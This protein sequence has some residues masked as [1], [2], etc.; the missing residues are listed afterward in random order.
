MGCNGNPHRVS[1]LFARFL[2]IPTCVFCVFMLL[3]SH[4]VLYL[5]LLPLDK[6][7]A[8]SQTI[9]S[10]AISWMQSII[11]II[12]RELC[13][14]LNGNVI[15]IKLSSL[16]ALL[17]SGESNIQNAINDNRSLNIMR[18]HIS[19]RNWKGGDTLWHSRKIIG[20]SMSSMSYSVSRMD[21]VCVNVSNFYVNSQ[22]SS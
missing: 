3:A 2:D 6:M 12:V 13:S 18:S 14:A 15:L 19:V 5:A 4:V 20:Q 16:A 9:F 1:P 10:D 22:H 7:A 8:V 21:S 11:I 17:L